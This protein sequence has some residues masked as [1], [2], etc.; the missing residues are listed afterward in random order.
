MHELNKKF[1]TEKMHAEERKRG[2]RDEIHD[3]RTTIRQR[4]ATIDHLL[5]MAND[6]DSYRNE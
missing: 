2:L 6:D 5:T 1:E 4:T 3:E